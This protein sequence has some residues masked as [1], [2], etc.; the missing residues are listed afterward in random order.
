MNDKPFRQ[1]SVMSSQAHFSSVPSAEIERSKFDR[2]HAHKTTFDAGKLIPVYIDEVM[3]GDTHTMHCTG[4]ARLA[5]PLRPIMDNL[6]MDTH[7]WFVPMRLVWSN[8]VNFMGERDEPDDDP[9]AYSIPQ[10]PVTLG[11]I[12]P[13]SMLSYL[14]LPYRDGVTTPISVSA[15]YTR[16][17]ALI[18]NEWYRDENLQSRVA[19]SKGA[20]PDDV[21]AL[22]AAD[23]CYPR[24]KRKDY[25]TGALPWPQK[26]DPVIVPL[27]DTAPV[28]GI[29]VQSSAGAS[30][31]A[32]VKE[33]GGAS[34]VYPNY[35]LAPTIRIDG[36]STK[37]PEVYADLSTAT[38]VS[39]ND[40]R[41]AFQIQRLLE[42]DARGGTRYIEL[43]FAHF[44]VRS[45]DARLQRPEYLGGGTTPVNV[46]PVVQTAMTLAGSSPQ[47]NLAAMG[48]VVTHAKFQK[49]FT[50]HG[51][52]VGLVFVRADLTYQQGIER[53]W[54]K[55][56]RYEFAWPAFA[57]LGEQAIFNR[58]IYAQGSA[59]DDGIF[60]YQ[61]AMQS[62]VISLRALLV[63]SLPS[64]LLPLTRGTCR[65]I[66]HLF[67]RSMV[68]SLRRILRLIG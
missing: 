31:N 14:G 7:F 61:S 8:W 52:L 55:K 26:G 3:P 9:D 65:R 56:T 23:S 24:G 58:E 54:S 49:S 53:F 43:I 41:T 48:T 10:M 5:T 28:Y 62:I 29:G 34:V 17:I 12:A 6:Y 68:R 66:L 67:L 51:I 47:G 18:Y 33:T 32:T 4:F 19:F 16:A 22:H 21:T 20:G 1:P 57:H 27:G 63:C 44:R 64:S 38:S 50:E 60:A 25:F 35:T 2:S 15:L 46:S 45:D 40:L 13:S 39:I 37:V 59:A 42:R 11:N 36:A 30:T